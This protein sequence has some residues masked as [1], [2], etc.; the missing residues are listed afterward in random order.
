MSSFGAFNALLGSGTSS[1]DISPERLDIAA[2]RAVQNYMQSGA[3]LNDSIV[4]EA[5]SLRGV[6]RDHVH[7]ICAAAN[8]GTFGALFKS[9]SGD[10]RVPTFEV[11][12]VDT[13]MQRMGVTKTAQAATAPTQ[14]YSSAPPKFRRALGE[15]TWGKVASAAKLPES[16]KLAHAF[17]L[18]DALQARSSLKAAMNK[19]SADLGRLEMQEQE[20]SGQILNKIAQALQDG[21]ALE[22][23]VVCFEKADSSEEG[24]KVAAELISTVML[25]AP[26][27][28]KVASLNGEVLDQLRSFEVDTGSPLYLSF[29]VLRGIQKEAAENRLAKGLLVEQYKTVNEFLVNH[30][31]A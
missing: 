24:A 8:Q 14:D 21:N 10:T 2:R 22:E 19:L 27:R 16:A 26:V 20:I 11:A 5:E 17:P 4:K 31:R 6:N 30:V 15:Q 25:L 29:S 28:Q 7:R 12:D 3:P 18:E 1:G 9:A 23:V 13:V